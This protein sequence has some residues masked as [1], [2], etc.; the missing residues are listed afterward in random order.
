MKTSDK[1]LV[2]P[3]LFLMMALSFLRIAERMCM[4]LEPPY[5]VPDLSGMA[6]SRERDS[7]L[8]TAPGD[9]VNWTRV[10]LG[11]RRSFRR[12]IIEDNSIFKDIRLGYSGNS[13]ITSPFF[14]PF[15]ENIL[16]W[17]RFSYVKT[18]SDSWKSGTSYVSIDIWKYKVKPE[19]PKMFRYNNAVFK[20]T[21]SLPGVWDYWM[22]QSACCEW[23]R[24]MWITSVRVPLQ[25]C[26]NDSAK[27]VE[28]R[29][30]IRDRLFIYY[31]SRE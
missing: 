31:R 17:L 20:E 18:E 29:D 28:L 13:C 21:E 5:S 3:I 4:R 30:Q 10:T 8:V 25:T 9:K 12:G 26:G 6:R 7:I 19:S 11:L 27:A 14:G 24:G 1:L 23:A 2:C 16:C 15:T 22:N